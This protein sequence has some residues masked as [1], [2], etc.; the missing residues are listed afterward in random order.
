[1]VGIFKFSGRFV[2]GLA[3][4]LGIQS[5]SARAQG[6]EK[7]LYSFCRL[8][9]CSDG[10][11]PEA[12]L[13]IDTS[14]NLYGTTYSG[15]SG[16]G[17]IFELVRGRTAWFLRTLRAL[18]EAP[19]GA[20]PAASLSYA[21]EQSGMRYDG[22]S[23][24][25]GT[26]SWGGEVG[27]TIFEIVPGENPAFH[28][29]YN[30][31]HDD[32]CT[33]GLYPAG[34]VLVDASGNLDVTTDA[35]GRYGYGVA[36]GLNGG[37]W[38]DFCSL[39]NCADGA[40]PLGG[41]IED[42][43]GNFY[44]TTGEGGGTGCGGYGCGTV[45]ELAPDDTET[46]LH[47]FADGEDGGYPYAGL[48]EDRKG[49][50]Y[51]TTFQG[52]GTGCGGYGCGTVFRLAPDGTETILHSFCSQSNCADGAAPRAVLTRDG[53]GN[54]IGTASQGGRTGCGNVGC[55]VAFEV[56]SGGSYSVL[57]AFCAQLRCRDGA[58]PYGGLLAAGNSGYLYGT[59]QAGG[60]A[61]DGVVFEIN[62]P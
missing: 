23:P 38:H 25:F 31:C 40:Q 60:A 10:A 6:T 61:G 17:T 41:L 27:G 54:F 12:G 21:G 45:F 3:V 62:P 49:N 9:N 30:F 15:G 29:V 22:T 35:G 1:M 53:K 11:S 2:F 43:A 7:V 39:S 5:G 19:D 47:S 28:V 46:V 48:I 34:S 44:G 59:T 52:G 24:L 50:L 13:I 20:G 16:Y 36:R 42:S 8:S 4:A 14:G 37:V 26:A 58:T 18:N 55:G 56:T 57:Y 51:G 33:D 32:S